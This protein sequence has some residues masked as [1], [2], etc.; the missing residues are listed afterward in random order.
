MLPY[1]LKEVNFCVLCAGAG[2]FC[3]HTT[4]AVQS[5]PI[6]L[7]LELPC[8]QLVGGRPLNGAAT[9][10]KHS[11]AFHKQTENPNL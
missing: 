5:V 7:W 11:F 9:N 8:D 6:K 10:Q 2:A 3:V 1:P 4:T